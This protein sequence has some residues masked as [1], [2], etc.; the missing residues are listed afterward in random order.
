[1][2]HSLYNYLYVHHTTGNTLEHAGVVV[3]LVSILNT[4]LWNAKLSYIM[5]CTYLSVT[6]AHS[7]KCNF[8][9]VL[10]GVRTSAPWANLLK[11]VTNLS[12]NRLIVCCGNYPERKLWT[13]LWPL[14][15]HGNSKLFVEVLCFWNWHRKECRKSHHCRSIWKQADGTSSHV[16]CSIIFK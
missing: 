1:M 11:R 12:V 14:C 4:Y 5:S 9:A 16:P 6:K 3:L 15:S 8:V 13:H 10:Q 2:R 7:A